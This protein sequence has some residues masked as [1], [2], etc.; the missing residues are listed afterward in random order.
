MIKL[1]QSLSLDFH[2]RY[3]GREVDV[4]WE[5]AVG[6]DENGLRWVGYTDNYIRVQGS[7]SAELFN[8]VTRTYLTEARADGMRGIVTHS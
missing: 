5:S 4:L 6:A 7:G 3:V 8:R 2:R 1:G